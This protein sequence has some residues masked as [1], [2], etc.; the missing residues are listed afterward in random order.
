M[1]HNEPEV[2]SDAASTPTPSSS[3]HISSKRFVVAWALALGLG[4]V[5]ADRFY[6]GYRRR[7]VLKLCTLGG[8]GVWA[9]VDVVELLS[10]TITDPDG[11]LLEGYPENKFAAISFTVIAWAVA[12]ATLA[13]F[14]WQGS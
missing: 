3:P 5:G 14:T 6:L 9:F 13:V 2:V 11:G 4:V 12:L 1:T 8:L 7:G 10:D